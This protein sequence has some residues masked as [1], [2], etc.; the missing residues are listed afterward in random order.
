MSSEG[1]ADENCGVMVDGCEEECWQ[2]RPAVASQVGS[3]E[4]SFSWKE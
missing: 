1:R 4:G 2:R 3:D